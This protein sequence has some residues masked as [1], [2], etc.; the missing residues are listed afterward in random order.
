MTRREVWHQIR[1]QNSMF[2]RTP[3]AAFFTILLPIMF[4]VLFNLLFGGEDLSG[5][6]FAQFFTP[7]IAVFA[8]VSATFTNLAIG[9][10][11][12]RD[13]G[14]LKRIRGTP[15][16]PWIY[17]AGRIGSAVYIAAV[18]IALM[19]LIGWA[20]YDFEIVWGRLHE[21]AIVFAVGI[22]T[23]SAL[24]LAVSGF[25][26]SSESVPAVANAIILPMAFVS[27][28][29]I[30]IDD[31]PAWLETVGDILPMKH[32]AA[33]FSDAFNPFV[34]GSVLGWGRLAVMLA[35]GVV[36]L[37]LTLRFFT[38]DPRE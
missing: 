25:V 1:H 20:L 22:S 3:V 36:A 35:W 5:V 24:G 9:T 4:L 30:Q 27:D 21:A 13:D 31:G 28:V 38:W 26:R 33:L 29:F 14:V 17:M 32:F 16:R 7:S 15:L 23:F 10:A 19:F 2:W 6:P 11:M 18:S 34:D 12:S 8:A 37:I